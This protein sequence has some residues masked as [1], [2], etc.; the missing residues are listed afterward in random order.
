MQSIPVLGFMRALVVG[1]IAVLPQRNVGLELAAE[2]MIFTG[3]AWNITFSF[4]RIMTS[5]PTDQE[6][7]M[8]AF[9]F[10]WWQRLRWVELPAATT[11]LV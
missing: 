6:E 3:Q 4:Y 11:G 7:A 8:R 2:L 9:H 1:L 10:S 5:L